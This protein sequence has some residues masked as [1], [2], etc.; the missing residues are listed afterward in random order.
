M[1][2]PNEKD[3]G[4]KEAYLIM[5]EKWGDEIE[6]KQQAD[7]HQ[8]VLYD[9]ENGKLKQQISE[10]KEIIKFYVPEWLQSIVRIKKI[11]E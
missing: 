9:T 7:A 8:C 2:R 3:F 11:L 5:L 1:K 10:L 6:I 4:F